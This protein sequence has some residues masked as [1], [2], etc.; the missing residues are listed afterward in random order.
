MATTTTSTSNFS[1]LVTQLVAA[2]AEEENQKLRRV[3]LT[4]T[5]L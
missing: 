1:D 4:V 3:D 5:K 2:R